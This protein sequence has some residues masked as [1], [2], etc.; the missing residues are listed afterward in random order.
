M[1]EVSPVVLVVRLTDALLYSRSIMTR[2]DLNSVVSRIEDEGFSVRL[3]WCQQTLAWN[4]SIT[5]PD[6]ESNRSVVSRYFGEA[7]AGGSHG[8]ASQY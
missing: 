1:S 4:M 5:G 2:A 3:W 7:A 8:T 6:E